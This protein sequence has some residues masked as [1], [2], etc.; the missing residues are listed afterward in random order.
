MSQFIAFLKSFIEDKVPALIAIVLTIATYWCFLFLN[1]DLLKTMG[2]TFVLI[3]SFCVY[4]CLII[5]VKSLFLH[6]R[7][8]VNNNKQ[9]KIEN[10][11]LINK[12][13]IKEQQK[14]EELDE[15]LEELR[16]YV[17]TLSIQDTKYLKR[18]VESG[19]KPIQIKDKIDLYGKLLGSNKVYKT[20]I[21]DGR[22]DGYEI[23]PA[24]YEY[25]L[26]DATYCLCKLLME[27]Y[28]SLSH[29]AK[30]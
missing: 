23:E 25:R 24:V 27:K 22:E 2:I 21:K 11:N 17:D 8:M 13:R 12:A 7:K 28:N 19:N 10:E 4:L 1:K 5:L 16:Y 15:V 14:I 26:T 18:L 29:S 3:F 9:E 6:I 30:K 20:L